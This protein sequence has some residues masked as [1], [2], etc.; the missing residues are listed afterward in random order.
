MRK[1]FERALAENPDDLATHRAYADWLAEQ[2][3]VRG[4]FIQ[5]QLALEDETLPAGERQDFRAREQRL[6]EE[7]ERAWLGR[8]ARFLFEKGVTDW[9]RQNNKVNSWR[10]A[11]GWVDS[12]YVWRLNLAASRALA[13]CPATRL[14]RSLH[15]ELTA[16]EDDYQ[17]QPGDGIP[18]GSE[19]PALYPLQN[20]PFLP[21]LRAFQFGATVD[22]KDG[23]YNSRGADGQGVVELVRGTTRLEE[24]RLLA[25]D[26]SLQDLFAL[27]L[28]HLRLLVVYHDVDPH[29]LEVLAANPTLGNL[30]TLRV[31]PAHSLDGSYLPRDQVRALLRSAHLPALRHLH[32]H[33]SDLGDLGCRDIV[34][35]GILKRLKVLDLSHG[36][37]TDAGARTLAA[38]PD[39]RR[40]DLLALDGNELTEEGQQLLQGLGI[41]VTCAGQHEPGEEMYLYSGDMEWPIPRETPWS[42]RWPWTPTTC[43]A[44]G[45]M[46]TG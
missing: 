44:T 10:W 18:P 19:Y 4:E 8:L 34:A 22:F 14:L 7:H 33:G 24:L 12:L 5:V 41:P 20:A 42:K 35:S 32:L 17:A 1:T 38:C 37:V 45:R 2:G 26:L 27:P 21:G 16:L 30:T 3:D 29:P 43:R 39:V 40:L 23:T 11:R 13:R 9:R 28:P 31:H 46:P 36:C 15:V 25:R 6:R